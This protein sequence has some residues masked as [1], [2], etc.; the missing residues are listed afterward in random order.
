MLYRETGVL[1]KL[2]S[3]TF[4][5][6]NFRGS[7]PILGFTV[8]GITVAHKDRRSLCKVF[9]TYLSTAGRFVYLMLNTPLLLC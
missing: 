3:E 2:Y 1:K 6:F 5:H 8:P 7:K 9:E 4:I